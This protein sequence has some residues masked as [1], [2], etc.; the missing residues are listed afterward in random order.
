MGNKLYFPK[1]ICL[2]LIS[3]QLRSGTGHWLGYCFDSLL[4]CLECGLPCE[5]V[6]RPQVFKTH[7]DRDSAS[8]RKPWECNFSVDN[9]TTW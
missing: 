6:R 9:S 4:P 5:S 1:Q 7:Y 8:V 2:H 3:E